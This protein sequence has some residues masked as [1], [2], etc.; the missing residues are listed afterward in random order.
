M[1]VD[2]LSELYDHHAWANGKILTQAALV[3]TAQ[4]AAKPWGGVASLHDTIAHVVGAERF[5]AARWRGEE[6]PPHVELKTI[7]ETE[8]LWEKTAATT[9]KFLAGLDDAAIAREI[10]SPFRG[11]ATL[12][13]G[14]AL[15]Q[16]LLH[17]VQHRSEAAALLTEFGHSPGGL[18]YL[19][20]LAERDA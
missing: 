4:A 11:G 1:D 14:I 9:R 19:N 12:T 20:F 18:D 2:H 10:G 17:S 8:A 13:V 3:S 6:R 16:V 5:W 7:A 15:T